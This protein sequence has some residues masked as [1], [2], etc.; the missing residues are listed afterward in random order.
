MDVTKLV[1][2]DGTVPARLL[3]RTDLQESQR[4]TVN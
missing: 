3:Q 1:D 4:V 2:V